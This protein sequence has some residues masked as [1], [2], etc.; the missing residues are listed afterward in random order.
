MPHHALDRLDFYSRAIIFQERGNAPERFVSLFSLGI[1]I[2]IPIA[3]LAV[4]LVIGAI[5]LV[6]RSKLPFGGKIVGVAL[7]LAILLV[8]M[9]AL[10]KPMLGN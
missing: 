5:Y 1:L 10:L 7:V 4:A 8:P 2:V 6:L 3:L 9:W